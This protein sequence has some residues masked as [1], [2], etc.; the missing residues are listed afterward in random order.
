MSAPG[1][2]TFQQIDHPILPKANADDRSRQEFAKS[3]KG[4]IQ[5]AILPGVKLAY[6]NRSASAFER[7]TGKPP[8]DRRDVRK[9]MLHDPYFQGYVSL[10]RISQELMWRSVID[11]VDRQLPALIEKVDNIPSA[12]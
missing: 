8:Q 4:Y 7:E 11:S 1:L 2:N 3:L 9:A 12:G 6:E 10:N 5:G